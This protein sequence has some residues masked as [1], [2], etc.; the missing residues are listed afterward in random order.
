MLVKPS[1]GFD[2]N[3]YK[4]SLSSLS[5]HQKTT[6]PDHSE[7]KLQS[8]INDSQPIYTALALHNFYAQSNRELSFKKGEII[9]VIRRIND[10]WLEGEHQ[11]L[12]GIFPINYVELFPYE[13][14]EQNQYNEKEQQIEGEAIV[15]YDFIPQK[16]VELQLR[17]GEKVILLR[18]LDNNWYEGRINHIEGIFPGDYIEIIRE[19]KDNTLN[20]NM[21]KSVLKNPTELQQTAIEKINLVPELKFTIQKCQVL[22]DYTPQNIDELELHVG[23]IIDILEKCDDG[24]YCGIMEKSN[25]GNNMKFGTFPGNYVKILST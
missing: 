4:F 20:Q 25:Y 19:P 21:P 8:T 24:W 13:T 7:S 6:D 23:D 17:K 3:R 18:K 11:G 12:K 9:Q 15:K 2:K 16:T 10:D 5:R 1:F 22:Y 14:I